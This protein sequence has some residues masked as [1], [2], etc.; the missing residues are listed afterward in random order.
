MSHRML[1]IPFTPE[2]LPLPWQ[3]NLGQNWLYLGLCKTIL[4]DFCTYRGVYL[5]GPSNAA[6]R[7]S[8]HSVYNCGRLDWMN[9]RLLNKPIQHKQGTF[10]VVLCFRSCCSKRRCYFTAVN[11][12]ISRFANA[13]LHPLHLLL[14]ATFQG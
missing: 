9:S 11:A 6:S 1:P 10:A 5:D 14:A 12:V 4:G 2:R 13:H 3:R 7:I 8:V